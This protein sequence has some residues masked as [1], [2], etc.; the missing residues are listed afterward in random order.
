MKKTAILLMMLLGAM[1]ANAQTWVGGSIGLDFSKTDDQPNTE[2]TFSPTIGYDFNDKWAI[3]L[4]LGYGYSY[5][6]QTSTYTPYNATHTSGSNIFSVTPFVRYTFA[7]AGIVSFF[8]DGFVG[9]SYTHNNSN[10][11][12]TALQSNASIPSDREQTSKNNGV[13]IGL[14]PGVAFNLNDHISLVSNLG[15]LSYY[16]NSRNSEMDNT[17]IETQ[18]TKTDGFRLKLINSINV[19]MVYKF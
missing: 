1:T 16:H 19:G 12:Y 17:P 5:N 2:I 7:E 8:V 13:S 9:Y 18:C 3:G 10:I 4:E 15:S 11:K 6:K 14:R